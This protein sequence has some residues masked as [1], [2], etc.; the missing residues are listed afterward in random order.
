MIAINVIFSNSPFGTGS[1]SLGSATVECLLWLSLCKLTVAI[2]QTIP[3]SNRPAGE[4]FLR[5]SVNEKWVTI[6][7]AETTTV[8][9]IRFFRIRSVAGFWGGAVMSPITHTPVRWSSSG[10]R[11]VCVCVC[12][13]IFVCSGSAL[14]V[15]ARWTN[16]TAW[17]CNQCW[18]YVFWITNTL[19]CGSRFVPQWFFHGCDSA[20]LHVFSSFLSPARANDAA[21]CSCLLPWWFT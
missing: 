7:I 20:P 6:S 11:C 16:R 3:F 5:S 14:S 17:E 2:T 21:A 9:S 12:V 1:S 19:S 4:P 8:A 10:L 13:D 15:W 18:L